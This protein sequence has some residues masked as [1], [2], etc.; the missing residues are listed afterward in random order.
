[1][2]FDGHEDPRHAQNW[3]TNTKIIISAIMIFNALAATFAS[4]IFSPAASYVGREFH[5][6]R[7]VTTLATSLCKS[8]G[9]LQAPYFKLT[10]VPSCSWLCDWPCSV[11]SSF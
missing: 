4:S 5:I 3:P 8:A 2:E 11:G 6:G 9:M 7:E 1:M 10:E